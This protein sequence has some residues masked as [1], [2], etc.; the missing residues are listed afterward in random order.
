MFGYIAEAAETPADLNSRI[1]FKTPNKVK[2]PE[3][4]VNQTTKSKEELSSSAATAI[5]KK[6]SKK[7]KNTAL[8]SF[9]EDENDD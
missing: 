7:G 1:V 8:L 4:K 6:T 2:N 5:A 9:D 3:N